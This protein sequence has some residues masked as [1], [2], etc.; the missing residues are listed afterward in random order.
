MH[1][2]DPAAQRDLA[3]AVG[4][5]ADA[6]ELPAVVLGAIDEKLPH[7]SAGQAARQMQILDLVLRHHSM[8]ARGTDHRSPMVGCET[9][10]I[11]YGPP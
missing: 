4:V 10:G 5:E 3:P 11:G 6:G 2:D 1:P 7:N 9:A 8:V